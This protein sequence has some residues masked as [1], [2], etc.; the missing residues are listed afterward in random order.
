MTRTN[1]K[2]K[3]SLLFLMLAVM[4]TGC[5]GNT[6]EKP[7]EVIKPTE[8][9]TVTE[10]AK[11][12]EVPKPTETAK[13]TEAPATTEI[14][15]TISITNT[16]TEVFVGKT[17]QFEAIVTPE[18]SNV[19]FAVDNNEFGTMTTEG[20]FTAT[21]KGHV[22]ITATI[23]GTEI[24]AEHELDIIDTLIDTTVNADAF[25]FTGLYDKNNVSFKTA[26]SVSNNVNTFAKI[27]DVKGQNYAFTAKVSLSNAKTD[28][29]WSRVSLGHL[30]DD[31]KFH[32][33]FVS[34]GQ[35]ADS[36]KAVV[37]DIVNGGV[38]WGA[39]TDRSQIWR[40]HDLY[41]LDMSDMT[42]TTIRKGN[43]Y[44]YLINGELYWYED[45]YRDANVI[46]TTP[47]FYVGQTQASFSAID[48]YTE[49]AKIDSMIDA[50]KN[51]KLYPS[52][53]KHVEINED[54]TS[55]KFKEVAGLAGANPKDYCAKSIGDAF[56]MPAGKESSVSF[57]MKI[58]AYGSIDPM[59]ALAV[60]INRHEGTIAESRSCVISETKAG[61]SGWNGNG[62]LNSGIGDGGRTYANDDVLEVGKNYK[63]TFTRLYAESGQDTKIRIEKEDGTVMLEYNHGWNTDGYTDVVYLSFLSRDLDCTLTNI[64]LNA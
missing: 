29:T 57:N 9:P 22:K 49:E 42:L 45:L 30:F 41:T 24:F 39:T 17:V 4:A 33:F 5:G 23:E 53:K 50:V 21:K 64:T 1:S 34:P 55:V 12:T 54:S 14:V 52:F 10:T 48:V 25:D 6:S 56:V 36:K 32:G 60:T 43:K 44:Y 8:T 61:F 18:G 16:E 47:A 63:V 58:D 26:D 38:L 28:D 3:R 13:P 7:T 11:P 27:K 19:I 31:G 51:K 59:P 46:D 2:M 15:K 35:N 37:M 62:N 20:L 40:Q